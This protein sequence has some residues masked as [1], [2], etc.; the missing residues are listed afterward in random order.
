MLAADRLYSIYEN[1]MTWNGEQE[2]RQAEVH[3]ESACLCNN[4]KVEKR[5][6]VSFNKYSAAETKCEFF[7]AQFNFH[8]EGRYSLSA[9][10][11]S[12]V[13]CLPDCRT[14]GYYLFRS[15][16]WVVG[17]FIF[18]IFFVCWSTKETCIW[19]GSS[20]WLKISRLLKSTQKEG[21]GTR[22]SLA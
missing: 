21:W 19:S 8:F 4:I 2:L 22:S 5:W 9:L 12:W 17:A 15:G 13:E 6:Y 10:R 20:Y 1:K 11:V 18:A 7:N 3:T 14:S 16:I